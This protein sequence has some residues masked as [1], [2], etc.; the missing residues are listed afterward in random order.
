MA[1]TSE[2]LIKCKCQLFG[3]RRL[4][5]AYGGRGTVLV[6]FFKECGVKPPQ[7]K[8]ATSRRTP[9]GRRR[10]NQSLL[11]PLRTELNVTAQKSVPLMLLA[12][13]RSR[14]CFGPLPLIKQLRQ[15][16]FG[17]L[18]VIVNFN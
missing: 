9:K 2:D 8:A 12:F 3:G 10:L 7:T 11:Q 17:F 6:A 13:R 5:G 4:V 16:R 14:G 18:I 15:T 1:R